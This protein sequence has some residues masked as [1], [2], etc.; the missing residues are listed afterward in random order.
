MDSLLIVIDFQERLI[1]R[2]QDAEEILRESAK[3]IKAC[4]ILG[5]PIIVTEQVKLGETVEEIRKLIDSKPIQKSSFSC[6]RSD[7]FM[8]ELKRMKPGKCIIV[9]IEAHI[10][11]LQTALDLLERGYEVHVALD[12]IGSRRLLD[13][14]AA[15]R[16]MTQRGVI[17]TTAETVIY[18]LLETAE[19]EKFKEILEIVKT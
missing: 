16:R 4:K 18:E 6:A 9:G 12:C 1:R 2:I 19:H 15:I 3:L 7:D 13:R 10:C 17:P 5:V 14:D 8:R 11:V